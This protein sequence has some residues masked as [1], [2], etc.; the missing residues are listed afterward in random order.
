MEKGTEKPIRTVDQ[1]GLE[2]S[3]YYGL[4]GYYTSNA[5]EYLQSKRVVTVNDVYEQLGIILPKVDIDE[6]IRSHGGK[7]MYC[8][9][10]NPEYDW[11][12]WS[13]EKPELHRLEWVDDESTRCPCCGRCNKKLV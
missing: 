3:D 1:D 11:W 12:G 9:V 7:P 8:R 13:K 10:R 6:A 4:Y 5:V 2:F